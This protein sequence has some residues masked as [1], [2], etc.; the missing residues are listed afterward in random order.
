M[1]FKS[2]KPFRKQKLAIYKHVLKINFNKM[3]KLSYSMLYDILCSCTNCKVVQS[4]NTWIL[5]DR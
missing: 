5:Y 4:N 1:I 3:A 2:E